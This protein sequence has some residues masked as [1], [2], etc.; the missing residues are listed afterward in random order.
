M[1]LCWVYVIQ[2]LPFI[3]LESSLGTLVK[4]VY[5]PNVDLPVKSICILYLGTKIRVPLSQCEERGLKFFPGV[6]P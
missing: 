5:I 2:F 4:G 3:S 1:L 6:Y